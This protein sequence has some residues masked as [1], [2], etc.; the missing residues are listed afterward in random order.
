LGDFAFEQE[1]EELVDKLLVFS[2]GL[3]SVLWGSVCIGIGGGL[4]R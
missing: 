2:I 3:V 4:A 1:V